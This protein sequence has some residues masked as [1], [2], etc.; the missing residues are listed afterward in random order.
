[1][2][3]SAYR[4]AV[5]D[6][7]EKLRAYA[8]ILFR[9][10]GRKLILRL[11]EYNLLQCK[12]NRIESSTA[13]A[14]LL[15]EFVTAK[16]ETYTHCDNDS[17]YVIERVEDDDVSHD[18]YC[19]RDGMRFLVKVEA[20][21]NADERSV[22]SQCFE[23]QDIGESSDTNAHMSLHIIYSIDEGTDGPTAMLAKGERSIHI[24]GLEIYCLEENLPCGKSI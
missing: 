20:N 9:V 18:F 11:E 19:I 14:T 5:K 8:S 22:D 21:C 16:L 10:Y 4:R 6:F 12:R 3:Y 2:D 7:E 17:E 23:R 13:I 1:M 15:R 24:D